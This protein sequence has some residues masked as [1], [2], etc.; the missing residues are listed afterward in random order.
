MVALSLAPL[1][2][3]LGSCSLPSA[4]YIRMLVARNGL[5]AG[6]VRT[7]RVL[8]APHILVLEDI[9]VPKIAACVLEQYQN[10][11]VASSDLVDLSRRNLQPP[12]ELRTGSE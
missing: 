5:A 12:K 9:V 6:A 7:A 10:R 1:P 11:L 3:N 8:H 4:E 2:T